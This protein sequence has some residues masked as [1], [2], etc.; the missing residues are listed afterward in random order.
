MKF[1]H[2][3]RAYLEGLTKLW[4][5]GGSSAPLYSPFCTL[6]SCTFDPV[7]LDN[8]TIVIPFWFQN[9]DFVNSNGE[10]FVLRCVEG[11]CEITYLSLMSIFTYC[12]II[13]PFWL[14]KFGLVNLKMK[15]S[16]HDRI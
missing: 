11:D 13:I 12:L 14:C 5:L 9:F 2:H 4:G 8:P 6:K 3:S 1:G 10:Y 7:P 16:L 15:C